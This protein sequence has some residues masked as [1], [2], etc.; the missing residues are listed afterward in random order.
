MIGYSSQFI[1]AQI[2]FSA[3]S[4]DVC[5]YFKLFIDKFSFKLTHFFIDNK[6][7]LKLSHSSIKVSLFSSLLAKKWLDRPF[8]LLWPYTL[9]SLDVLFVG[10]LS[11]LNIEKASK[12]LKT[13]GNLPLIFHNIAFVLSFG[14]AMDCFL[15]LLV[16]FQITSL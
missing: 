8:I 16:F 10:M 6:S 12:I 5:Y 7:D 1:V 13:C 9:K 4:K 11:K 15:Y 3:H 14:H 2:C